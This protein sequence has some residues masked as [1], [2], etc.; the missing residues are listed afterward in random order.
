MIQISTASCGCG[1]P[2][3]AG[4]RARPTRSP[5]APPAATRPITSSRRTPARSPHGSSRATPGEGGAERQTG[6][7]GRLALPMQGPERARKGVVAAAGQ[8]VLQRRQRPVGERA[9]SLQPAATLRPLRQPRASHCMG[10][11]GDQG[12]DEGDEHGEVEPR[13]QPRQ[14]VEQRQGKEQAGDRDERPKAGPETLPEERRAGKSQ[15]PAVGPGRPCRHGSPPTGASAISSSSRIQ[16]GMRSR[17][18]SS[19]TFIRGRM[20]AN[21]SSETSTSGTSGRTL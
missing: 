1:A 5:T 16:P 15:H 17:A 3:T 8:P 12:G 19:S 18:S 13:G 4:T 7:R 21:R 2:A 11:G 14:Q 9:V 10:K 6:G 20:T